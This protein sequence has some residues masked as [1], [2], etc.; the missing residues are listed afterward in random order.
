M[1]CFPRYLYRERF[2]FPEILKSILKSGF[3]LSISQLNF[4]GW[5]ACKQTHCPV[6]VTHR[7]CSACH[8]EVSYDISNIKR[9]S[10]IYGLKYRRIFK[11]IKKGFSS[12]ARRI[13]FFCPVCLYRSHSLPPPS[14]PLHPTSALC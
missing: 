9:I 7:C 4:A 1:F 5:S 12:I 8:S 14:Y 3:F 6:S 11:M 13:V 2:L 10:M